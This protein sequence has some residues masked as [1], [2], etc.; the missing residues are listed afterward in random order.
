MVG[1][2]ATGFHL[3]CHEDQQDRWQRPGAEGSLR[4][5]LSARFS[6]VSERKARRKEIL[7]VFRVPRATM[8]ASHA[9]KSKTRGGARLK[10]GHE[11]TVTAG[12][13][14]LSLVTNQAVE[15]DRLAY[16]L[17]QA[18]S[19]PA[20]AIP[21]PAPPPPLIINGGADTQHQTAA[22]GSGSLSSVDQAANGDAVSWDVF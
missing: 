8:E 12:N 14:M 22:R 13:W 5:L 3:L 6:E 10:A 2:S 15:I 21:A 19:D 1:I 4:L 9:A 18:I 20:T 7:F 11:V 16:E 17:E